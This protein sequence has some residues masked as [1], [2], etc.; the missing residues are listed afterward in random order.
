MLLELGKV[1]PLSRLIDAMW[2]CEPPVTARAQ[3]Q[4]CIS[5][6]RRTMT[7]AGGPDLIDTHSHGYL[8]RSEGSTLDLQAFEAAAAGGRQSLAAGNPAEAVMKFRAALGL[9][10]GPALCDIPSTLVQNSVA[11]INE[12]KLTVLESCLQAELLSGQFED[13]AAEL[14]K[15]TSEY[16][17]RERLRALQMNVL[18]RVGRQAEALEV[19][20]SIHS[21]LTSELGIE[22]SRELQVLHQTM[23]NG[24][25]LPEWPGVAATRVSAVSAPPAAVPRLLPADIPDFTGRAK[26]VDGVIMTL[27]AATSGGERSYAVPISVLSGPGGAGKTTLAVHIAHRLADQFPD[28]QLFARL[29]AGDRPAGPYEVLGRFLRALGVDGS[30]LPDSVEER[31][32]MYRDLLSSKQVLVALDDVMSQEQVCPLL[33]GSSSCAVL[34]TSRLR[35][36]GLSAVQR[37]EVGAFTRR[38]ALELLARVMGAGRIQAEPDAADA[39]C[40]LCGDRPLA[41]RIVAARLAARPHWSVAALVDRLADET[42]RLDELSYGDMGVRDSIAI[43]YGNLSK[44]AQR[45]LRLL[46]LIEAPD[47]EAWVG[48]PL[49]E[50]DTR[51]AAE[52]IEELAES[53]LID[54]RHGPVTDS[55]RYRFHDITRPFA[56]ERL[57]SD[58]SPEA[59]YAA[60]ARVTGDYRLLR[61]TRLS[62]L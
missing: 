1:I 36:T 54:A 8:I 4:I 57:L 12:H 22:P 39:L 52:L 35:L 58:E 62:A 55:V 19:Y 24:D 13:V 14:V 23:L 28:G 41:L 60:L 30:S 32:E 61:P 11:H 5:N 3:V 49:L 21:T 56:R 33:P 59:R 27:T 9:W 42:R 26:I 51:R 2:D 37:S 50:T 6:L 43:S 18:Y 53:Y 16:P 17:L 47:F 29:R 46:A 10:R 40:Q 45:L 15:L 34:I 25:Q 38:S 31:A 7:A 48:A 20:R 44:N